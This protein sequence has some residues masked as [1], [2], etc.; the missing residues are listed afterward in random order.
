MYETMTYTG[1]VHKHNEMEE[2]IEDL[3]GFILQK[4]DSQLDITLTIAVPSD[5]TDKIEEKANVLLGDVELSPLASTEIAVVSPTLARQHLP[6]AACDI[7]EYLRRYGTKTNMIGLA[8]GAGKG[9]SQISKT[10]KDLIE[11]HDLAIFSMGSFDDCIR[12]K[13]H[14]FEDIDIPVIVTGSPEIAAE[15]I[16]ANAYVS[17]FGRIPRR[18][19]R[20]ENIRALRRLVE[21]S[22]DIISQKKD[23]LNDDP[24]ILSPIIVKIGLERQVP[25]VEHINSPMALVSQLDGVRVKLPY[26][27]FHKE[28]EEVEIEGYR[29][30]D[31]AE[32]KK[33]KMYDHILVKILSESSLLE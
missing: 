25:E 23:D 2:L 6:H 22:E 4:N 12:K 11:E 32:I 33:S 19:K 27:Q 20:G 18:L 29:L 7:A 24:L 26:D 28:I 14:L 21:V 30:G 15:E 13:K 9:I 3:G 10:E 1:G 17:D 8:R 31:I 16:N 5:D